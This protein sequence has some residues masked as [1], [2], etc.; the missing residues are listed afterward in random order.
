MLERLKNWLFGKEETPQKE[1]DKEAFHKTRSVSKQ[2]GS[3]YVNLPQEWFNKNDIDPD[4]VEEVEILANS[5]IIIVN[6]DRQ[7]E[8]KKKIGQ[9]TYE[10]YQD[11]KNQT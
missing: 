7:N 9:K 4:E 3:Y 11:E 10:V 8:I 2:G 5:D 6:P 1:T